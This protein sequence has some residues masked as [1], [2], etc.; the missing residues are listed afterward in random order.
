MKKILFIIDDLGKG[1]AEKV[2]VDLAQTLANLG[3]SVTLAVL[4]SSKNTITISPSIH[5]IDLNIDP[6][7][8]FG[9]LWNTKKLSSSEQLRV[10]QLLNQSIFDLIIV[11]FHNGYYL[12]QYLS[13]K[14]NVWYWIHGELLEFRPSQNLFK[15]IK[16]YIRQIKYH[17]KFKKLFQL[18]NLITV[19]SD[20]KYKYQSLL[21]LSKIQHI[22]NGVFIPNQFLINQPE[23]KWDVIFVGRLASIKQIDHAI[24]AFAR[25]GL[26]G[27]MAILGE[28]SQ[29]EQL[30]KLTKKLN[31]ENRV[32]FLG[33]VNPP[34]SLIQ[35][36]KAL[37]LT[38]H[39]EAYGLVL[40]ESLCLNIPVIAYNCSQGV[41]DIFSC[42]QNMR[43]FLIEPNNCE[44]L[45]VK[46]YECVNNPYTII[47][48][49]KSKLSI[50]NTAK[51]FL[52]LI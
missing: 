27:K 50:H 16:E 3:H 43:P 30:I 42:Q 11:G 4:N 28:G 21:P 15:L 39:Y 44:E 13:Q 25:S 36:S 19:N 47:E 23:K 40:A 38:S 24:T 51:Q 26:T 20:L 45:S 22:P 10:D 7:F 8:A 41:E 12:G 31:I 5:Y 37:I 17:S 18:K 29:K 48:A 35:Q 52:E 46:L 6:K 2:T 34:Y 32:D 49:T 1:G 14:E 33:W 9:K